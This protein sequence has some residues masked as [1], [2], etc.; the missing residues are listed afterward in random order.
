MRRIMFVLVGSL[1][2]VQSLAA[3]PAAPREPLAERVKKSID[4]GVKYLKSVQRANGSW[5]VDGDVINNAAV[6]H[7]GGKTALAL[8]AVLNAGLTTNDPAVVLALK[9]LRSIEPESTYVRGL[10][11][12]RVRRGGFAG[13]SP[14]HPEQRQVAPRRPRLQRR[15]A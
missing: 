9:N 6:S 1:L 14:A 15:R 3:Q 5:E 11:N 12:P 10:A 13:G 7:P 2:M 4:R 8:L